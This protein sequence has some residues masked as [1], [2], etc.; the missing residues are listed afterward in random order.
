MLA[1]RAATG[2]IPGAVFSCERR[3]RDVHEALDSK[4]CPRRRAE[5]AHRQVFFY[6]HGGRRLPEEVF[7]LARRLTILKE[8]R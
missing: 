3:G 1:S 7:V 5:E 8:R 2:P 4:C 6:V